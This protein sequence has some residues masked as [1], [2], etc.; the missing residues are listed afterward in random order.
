MP[1]ARAPQP[2]RRTT[3]R[4]AASLGWAPLPGGG[5]AMQPPPCHRHRTSKVARRQCAHLLREADGAMIVRTIINDRH[6]AASSARKEWGRTRD[7][8]SF[9]VGFSRHPPPTTTDNLLA[10]TANDN[11]PQISVKRISDKRARR[12]AVGPP[13]DYGHG[14]ATRGDDYYSAYDRRHRTTRTTRVPLCGGNR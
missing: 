13:L 1:Q 12:G 3:L 2:R 5:A 4:L 10:I 9:V 11:N 7:R 6:R 8:S 14:T